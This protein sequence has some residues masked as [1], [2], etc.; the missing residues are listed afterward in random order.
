MPTIPPPPPHHHH[1]HYQNSHHPHH[2]LPRHPHHPNHQQQQLAAGLLMAGGAG[3]AAGL[4]PHLMPSQSE[5]KMLTTCEIT[6]QQL[7]NETE[8][9][10]IYAVSKSRGNFAALLVQ[11]MYA[12]HERIISNVMGTRGKR[13]L[14]A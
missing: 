10:R 8:V 11:Q 2:Q 9:K 5:L 7:I 12:R 3:A 14:W 4:P 13:Q 1:N 6:G